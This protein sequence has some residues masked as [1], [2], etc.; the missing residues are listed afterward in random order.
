MDLLDIFYSTAAEELLA[1]CVLVQ[2]VLESL[3]MAQA[4]L[5]FALDLLELVLHLQGPVYLVYNLLELT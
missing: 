5:C 2:L 1:D 4:L 3:R